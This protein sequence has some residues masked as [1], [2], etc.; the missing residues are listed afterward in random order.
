MVNFISLLRKSILSLDRYLKFLLVCWLILMVAL[1]FIR[2]YIG[3]RPFL[4]G[5]TLLVLFQLLYVLQ[6]LYRAWGWWYLLR[7]AVGVV[8]LTWAAEAIG[9]RSGFPYGNHHF[10]AS[11]QPHVMGV[12]FLIPLMWLMMLPPAWAVASLITRKLVGCVVRPLFVVSSALAFTAWNLYL[13]PSMVRWGLVEWTTPDGYFGIPWLNFIGQ[14][15]V[16]GMISFA[17]SPKRLPAGALVLVYVLAWLLNFIWQLVFWGLPG[18]ALGG[19][20]CM[21]IMVVFAAVFYR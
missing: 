2:Q 14:I 11:L 21:G 15:F 1:P 18:S 13:A 10:A 6:V 9:I 16:A 19:F 7:L 3:E 8:L 12:P 4:Q 20:F 5:L 17:V